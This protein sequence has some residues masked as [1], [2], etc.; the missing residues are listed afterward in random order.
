MDRAGVLSC[1]HIN[2]SDSTQWIPLTKSAHI[3]VVLPPP[4]HFRLKKR[5]PFANAYGKAAETRRRRRAAG[6]GKTGRRRRWPGEQRSRGEGGKMHDEQK[7]GRRRSCSCS[8]S[9]THAQAQ[10][11]CCVPDGLAHAQ[12][13]LQRTSCICSL[14]V[15]VGSFCWGSGSGR[16]AAGGRWC[17]YSG[18]CK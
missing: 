2:N 12:R 10:R 4:P 15:G 17:A 1:T 13:T 11:P 16:R 6:G 9:S 3:Q 8:G 7:V 5:I 14:A 18:W